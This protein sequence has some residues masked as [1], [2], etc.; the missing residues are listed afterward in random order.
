MTIGVLRFSISVADSAVQELNS[1]V[2]W[3]R[4]Q[5]LVDY[6]VFDADMK[7]AVI[8]FALAMT[9]VLLL[10][11]RAEAQHAGF[12]TAV[13]AAH[14]GF[15]RPKRHKRSHSRRRP[16]VRVGTDLS[17]VKVFDF[18]GFEL[19]CGWGM[20]LGNRICPVENMFEGKA[21]LGV[22]LFESLSFLAGVE[23]FTF[24]ET[25]GGLA[26]SA[27]IGYEEYPLLVFAEYERQI[28]PDAF[29]SIS[30]GLFYGSL[31]GKISRLDFGLS[32]PLGG[33]RSCFGFSLLARWCFGD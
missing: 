28:L 3:V 15:S 9:F 21:G 20:S 8:L 29:Y 18:S 7:H 27:R 33:S 2:F 1:C 26:F 10:P 19:E 17:D 13:D 31:G 25:T 30:L 24:E 16:N 5:Y 23:V 22:R 32:N 12:P 6:S 4:L 11:E 14:A